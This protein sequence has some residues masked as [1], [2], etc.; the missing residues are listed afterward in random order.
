MINKLLGRNN[1]NDC[2]IMSK[3]N[4][5]DNSLLERQSNTFNWWKF[6]KT[7][8]IILYRVLCILLIFVIFNLMT[9]GHNLLDLN[10]N[11]NTTKTDPVIAALFFSYMVLNGVIIF[12]L[13]CIIADSCNYKKNIRHPYWFSD[14]LLEWS[15]LN[16]THC[17]AWSIILICT[18]IIIMISH[19]LGYVINIIIFDVHDFFGLKS[20]IVGYL[21]SGIII[22]LFFLICVCSHYLKKYLN[23]FYDR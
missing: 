18:P 21:A 17:Y 22:I 15:N 23:Q 8:F 2:I 9:L 1:Y 5:I 3:I 19:G 10:L 6:F 7:S 13:A 4:Y 14:S 12:L 20:A 16:Y 11:V